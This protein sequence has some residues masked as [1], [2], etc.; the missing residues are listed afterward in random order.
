MRRK[1]P[2]PMTHSGMDDPLVLVPYPQEFGSSQPP[3][4]KIAPKMTMA[5]TP[6]KAQ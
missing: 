2:A 5:L 3:I 6:A 1:R 4:A